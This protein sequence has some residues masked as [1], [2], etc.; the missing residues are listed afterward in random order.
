[1]QRRNDDGAKRSSA[2]VG[3]FCHL[4][5]EESPTF[6]LKREEKGEVG[7]QGTVIA[8]HLSVTRI[9]SSKAVY[10]GAHKVTS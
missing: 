7:G 6:T 4:A 9:V 8:Q 2:A 1:M 10:L 3:L 5:S